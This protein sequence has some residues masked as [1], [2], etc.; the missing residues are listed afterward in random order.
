MRSLVQAAFLATLMAS[1]IASAYQVEVG[2]MIEKTKID[3]VDGDADTF[4]LTGKYYLAPVKND[5]SPLAEAAFL[6]KTGHLGLNFAR[7]DGDGESLDVVGISGEYYIPDSQFYVSAGISR[8]SADGAEDGDGYSAEFGVMPSQNLLL[9][10]GI[11]DMSESADAAFSVKKGFVTSLGAG[12]AAGEDSAPT[13]R[14][15]YVTTLGSNQV[16]LEGQFIFGDETGYMFGGDLYLD[17]TLS[18]GASIADSTADNSETIFNLR[19][20]KFLTPAVAVGVAYVS[21]DEIS[22]YGLNLT[23]RF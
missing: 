21:A 12:L 14:G 10:A 19:A 18:I 4:A 9:A 15:K 2:G 3:N 6:S 13:L 16:N 23:G 22:S 20:Q 8:T 7:V 17:K 1:S 5:A 11:T